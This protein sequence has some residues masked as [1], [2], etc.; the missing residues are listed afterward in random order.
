MPEALD[1]LGWRPE[2]IGIYP[3]RHADKVRLARRWRTETSVTL[4]WIAEELNMGSWKSL[5]SRLNQKK[6][7]HDAN[8]QNE[9]KLV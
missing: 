2:Q 4:R 3:Q 7:N 5:A 6:G 8:N 9:F 1:K